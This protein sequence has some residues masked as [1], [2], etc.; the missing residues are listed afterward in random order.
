MAGTLALARA[1]CALWMAREWLTARGESAGDA[2]KAAALGQR[3]AEE[4]LAKG[5]ARLIA[6]RARRR[7]V[8]V[9]AAVSTRRSLRS[10]EPVVVTRAEPRDGPLSSRA[11]QPRPAGAAVAR[12]GRRVGTTAGRSRQRSQ[13]SR[14]I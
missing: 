8:A 5:A 10:S 1:V 13:R 6:Q 14:S 7:A 2:E 12:R 4:L 3:L 11:A 9:E